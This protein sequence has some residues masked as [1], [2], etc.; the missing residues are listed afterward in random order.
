MHIIDTK[1]KFENIINSSIPKIIVFI[2]DGCFICK[3]FLKEMDKYDIDFYVF[4]VDS[5]KDVYKTYKMSM[6]YYM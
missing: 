2:K 5:L 4:D 1:E 3:R 6:F